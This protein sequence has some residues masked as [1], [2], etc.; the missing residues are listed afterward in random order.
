M[1]GA[2][3]EPSEEQTGLLSTGV[4]GLDDVLGGGLTPN[5]LYLIEGTPGAGK[6]TIAI[7]VLRDGVAHG[8]SVLYVTLSETEAELA[9]VARSHGWDIRG[10]HVREMLPSLDTLAPDEQYTMFHP[11][12]VELSETTLRI[13]ADVDEIKP[14]RVV[15]DSLSELRLLAGSSLRYRRQI[16]ALKQF[17]TG[18]Q[19]TVLLLDDLTATEQDLQVQSIAHA[20][21]RLEQLNPGYGTSR[22]RL[23]VPKYRG[24]EYRG[25]YHDYKIVR[26]GLQVYPRL[27]AA[28]HVDPQP[29]TKLPSD[30]PELDALLGGGIE[31]GTS[32]LLVGA[33]GT[34][35]SS[36]AVQFAV[37]AARR[38]EHAAL[39]I[40][41]ESIN[42][43]RTRTESMGIGLGQCIDSGQIQVRQVDPAELS[44]VDAIRTAVTVQNASVIV[45]DS[46]NGYLNAM[47]DERFLTVQLH[48]LLTYLGQQG[49]ATL[50]I[51][52]HHGVI[53]TQMQM[54]VDASYLADA[55]VLLRYY[56]HAGEVLQAISVLKKR[57]GVHERTIR[58]FSL[59]SS[60][61]CVG[62]PLRQ[63]RG[64]LTGV[65]VP[66]GGERSDS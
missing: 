16:L 35:K 42:T 46:L 10:I 51:G 57:G 17:F 60:G 40:F 19:C 32:T 12:E 63:F 61:I 52:A 11:S 53:G 7:Q 30:L 14:T 6:T 64:I 58:S 8:E 49:V 41:D 50:L 48:E 34:G 45:I 39:F 54:P 56:E 26:G 4:P 25:G 66:L 27:I 59:T 37:A 55:V 38:G 28:E 29:Q 1:S 47:P 43:L 18:R 21:I 20:V 5:R 62:P 3:S 23:I 9:G 44:F 31:K 22:R 15:F 13:L 24:K 33:P 65:P 2:A 36:M